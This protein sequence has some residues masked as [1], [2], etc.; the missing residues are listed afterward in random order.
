MSTAPVPEVTW[1]GLTVFGTFWSVYAQQVIT[2]TSA[3]TAA[4]TIRVWGRR[5]GVRALILTISC[6]SHFPEPRWGAAWVNN[7]PEW[8]HEIEHGAVDVY[9]RWDAAREVTT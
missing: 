3:P 1:A 4:H 2:V 6:P 9:E 7:P 5:C 8:R